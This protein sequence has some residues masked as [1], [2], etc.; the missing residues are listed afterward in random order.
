MVKGVNPHL[1]P[2]HSEPSSQFIHETVRTFNRDMALI[3]NSFAKIVLSLGP[4]TCLL[5]YPAM[6]QRSTNALMAQTPPIRPS[7]P[8]PRT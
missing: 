1:Q 7:A 5:V 8:P 6:S 4:L 3:D 2:G